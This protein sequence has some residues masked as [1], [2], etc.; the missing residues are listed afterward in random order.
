MHVSFVLYIPN[1]TPVSQ[2][3]VS[4]VNILETSEEKVVF[5][6]EWN[7]TP[8]HSVEPRP[9]SRNHVHYKH[10]QYDIN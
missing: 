1:G 7:I 9:S 3:K 4:G 10:W 2:N 5:T 6:G 8:Q